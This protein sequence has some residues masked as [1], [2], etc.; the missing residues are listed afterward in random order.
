MSYEPLSVN[1]QYAAGGADYF[2]N[3]SKRYN[4]LT[5]SRKKAKRGQKETRKIEAITGRE[6]SIRRKMNSKD[7]LTRKI[8][9]TSINDV[10]SHFYDQSILASEKGHFP[11]LPKESVVD[12]PVPTKGLSSRKRKLGPPPAAADHSTLLYNA[13]V[14]T[15][16][17]KFVDLTLTTPT[18]LIPGREQPYGGSEGTPEQIHVPKFVPN[19]SYGGSKIRYF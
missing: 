13:F 8:Y 4:T 11:S 1:L 19:P 12:V 15:N 10:L 5:V 9:T 7:K 18:L 16:Y 14:P 2:P 6:G 17:T 3:K